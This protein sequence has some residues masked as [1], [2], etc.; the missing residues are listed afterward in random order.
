MS[1]KL[2]APKEG[3]EGVCEAAPENSKEEGG[4]WRWQGQEEGK[5]ITLIFIMREKYVCMRMYF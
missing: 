3:Y 4:I 1:V 2:S 5:F